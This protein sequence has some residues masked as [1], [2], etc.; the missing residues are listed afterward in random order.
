MT[1]KFTMAKN[2]KILLVDDDQKFG[3]SLQKILSKS[4]FECFYAPK[5][6]AALSFIKVHDIQA[7]VLDCMLPQMNGI[8]L[9][10]KIRETTGGSDLPIFFMS[11]I[12][13]DRNFSISAL[14]KTGAKSFL[15]K[16]FDATDLANQL[17]EHIKGEKQ[18]I[19]M[20]E[21]LVKNL[22]LQENITQ[23]TVIN[24]INNS[25][26][27]NAFEVPF[28]IS[29][30][31]KYKATGCLKI[32]TENDSRVLYFTEGQA[33]LPKIDVPFIST[34]NFLVSKGWVIESDVQ[35]INDGTVQALIDECLVSPHFVDEAYRR[36]T[37]ENFNTF[38]TNQ[39]VGASFESTNK[40]DNC[41]ALEPR[42][43]DENIYRWITEKFDT[44]W[45]KTYYMSYFD[46]TL[47]PLTTQHKKVRSFSL[48]A[49]NK[50]ILD[51]FMQGKTLTEI[52]TA[53]NGEEETVLKIF[54]L[55]LTYRE[56]IISKKKNTNA[57]NQ[58]K[59]LTKLVKTMSAQNYFERLGLSDKANEQEI[60][61]SYTELSQTLHPDKVDT[62]SEEIMALSK[63][64]Y[65]LIQEAYNNLK[66]IELRTKYLTE[67][68]KQQ[69]E[70][71]AQADSIL[72][73]ALSC[74]MRGDISNAQEKISEANKMGTSS[75]GNILQAW[76]YIKSRKQSPV[77]ISQLLH[78]VSNE[79]RNSVLYFHVKGLLHA[80][81]GEFDK[82]IV[83]LKNALNRD[84]NFISSRRELTLIEQ[85]MGNSKKSSKNILT[86]DL[87]DVVGLFFKKK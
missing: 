36:L 32:N 55:L 73:E 54:H 25:K 37:I 9:A 44:T 76:C 57:S 62:D 15:I 56:L 24:A 22:L 19:T 41:L 21:N 18:E 20:S 77:A 52:I 39:S 70:Q 59:R 83:T 27:I 51:L 49:S 3:E 31:S 69:S 66:S 78:S 65:S 84:P 43:V 16:P 71:S 53:I 75:K 72:D 14:K 38:I 7:V 86:A 28:L 35:G 67:L 11:G 46:H 64:V 47:K 80:S 50:Q 29:V 12:Y 8:D 82:A 85:K 87:K 45:L 34:K 2:P 4:G 10:L 48:V 63:E 13:K 30:L 81:Q 5:P 33:L 61:K 26:V 42:D 6:Q 68:K 1:D 74:L 60:K 40:A 58:L 79:D 17:S 23:Q